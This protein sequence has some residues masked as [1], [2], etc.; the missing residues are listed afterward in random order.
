MG[1]HELIAALHQDGAAQI[2]AIRRETDAAAEL[3]AEAATARL[4]QLRT[5]CSRKQAAVIAEE[6]RGSLAAAALRGRMIRFA[7]EREL[8]ERLFALA[9]RSLSLVAEQGGEALFVSL[10][11]EL[12]SGG[13]EQVRV[14][15]LT[16]ELARRLFPGAEILPDATVAAGMEVIRESGALRIV[17]TLEKRLERG[18][19]EILPA[20]LKEVCQEAVIDGTAEH[21]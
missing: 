3:I 5:A 6:T 18:W 19:P 14:N 9:Q 8:A 7:A 17:N 20:L 1:Y 15:P 21:D 4:Q 16:V 2:E 11:E 12:P 13:W 10:A